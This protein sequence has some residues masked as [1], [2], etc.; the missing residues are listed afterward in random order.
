M[1][2]ARRG[3]ATRFNTCHIRKVPPG[4]LIDI[5]MDPMRSARRG[6]AT[7][8][9]TCH[10]RATVQTRFNTCHFRAT[11]QTRFNTCLIRATVQIRFNTCHIRK[12]PPGIYEATVQTRF[13]TCHIRKVPPG[14]YEA[15]VQ[16]KVPP[17]IY[18]ATVQPKVPSG[19]VPL[20]IY[21][22]IVPFTS[23]LILNLFYDTSFL[24][25]KKVII[26][27][28]VES[29]P[30]PIASA[31]AH[32]AAVGCYYNTARILSYPSYLNVDTCSCQVQG[33]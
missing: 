28:D 8:F 32:R 30:G 7:R 6:H 19:I 21:E 3:H 18:E 12:V 13:N 27:G 25:R 16:P 2:S 9:N 33:F 22:A 4:I 15:T 1:R 23:V 5:M 14:I 11:V 31:Q 20:G 29:N 24:N 10:F 17:G 26:D